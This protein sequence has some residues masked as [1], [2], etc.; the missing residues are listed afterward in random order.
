MSATRLGALRLCIVRA[1]Y[2]AFGG[3]ERFVNLALDALSAEGAEITVLARSW[4]P[5]G[6]LAANVSV[7]RC[8]PFYLGAT[9]RDAGFARA[10]RA[11]LRARP[12]DLVQSHERIPGVDIYRAG[13]GVH[14]AWLERRRAGQS[15]FAR[16]GVALNLHHRYLCNAERRLFEHPALRAVICNSAMVRDEI[17]ARFAIDPA[18]L[19]II[20]NGVDLQRFSLSLAASYRDDMRGQLAIAQTERVLLFVGSGF[21]R[22]GLNAALDALSRGPSGVS[23]VV[24]GH[25]K[26]LRRYQNRAAELG[27]EKRCRFV[28]AIEDPAPYYAMADALILPTLYDPFPNAALEA[29][30]SGLPVLTSTACGARE[31]I[32]EGE[33][34]WVADPL[35]V[36]TIAGQIRTFAALDALALARMRAAARATAEGFDVEQM[37]QKLFSLYRELLERK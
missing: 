34:G 1:R 11:E 17:A 36:T 15:F 37:G 18:K 24:V 21:L 29:L 5:R 2:S 3:A 19:H 13:D 20:H 4:R 22:K 9:W 25:D 14:A 33:N 26:H 12:F 23:L 30:A 35:D 31:V 27:I 16:I 8:D 6:A 32:I 28:G 7:V 10:V